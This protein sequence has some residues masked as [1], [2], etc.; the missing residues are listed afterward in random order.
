MSEPWAWTDRLKKLALSPTADPAAK[1]SRLPTEF[2]PRLAVEAF[3]TEDAGRSLESTL[4][5]GWILK[6]YRNGQE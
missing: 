6:G 5:A 1:N 2:W 3:E 4:M